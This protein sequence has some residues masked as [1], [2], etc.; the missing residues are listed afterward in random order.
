MKRLTACFRF[1][2]GEAT[3]AILAAVVA[4]CFFAFVAGADQELV[5]VLLGLGLLTAML[6]ARMHAA[7]RDD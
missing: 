6:E 4:V 3:A 5:L 1:V 2:T 7:G